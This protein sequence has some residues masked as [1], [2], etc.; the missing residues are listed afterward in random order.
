[1]RCEREFCSL[2]SN[3]QVDLSVYGHHHSYQRTCKVEDMVCK[4]LSS[5]NSEGDNDGYVA[6]VHVVLGMAGMGLS[7]NMVNP[8]PE[9]IEYATDR[10]FGLCTLVADRSKLQLSFILNSDGQVRGVVFNL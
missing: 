10:E 5:E 3:F 9:W 7:Q 6:P 8:P 2:V 4:G 1:M